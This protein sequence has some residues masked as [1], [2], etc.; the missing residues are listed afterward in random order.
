MKFYEIDKRVYRCHVQELET[1]NGQQTRAI[2]I[3]GKT[4]SD[5]LR[6]SHSE[7]FATLVGKR[8]V[9]ILDIIFKLLHH[10][11]RFYSV[12]YVEMLVY[13]LKIE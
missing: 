10:T 13:I 11:F 9:D 12:V 8:D 5:N 3:F 6:F 2:K 1:L 7:L 4:L